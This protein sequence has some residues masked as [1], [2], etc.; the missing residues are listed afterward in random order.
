MTDLELLKKLEWSGREEGQAMCPG[1]GVM[2]SCCP[3]CRGINP[4][5]GHRGGFLQSCW[6]HRG[7]CELGKLLGREDKG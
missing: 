2:V 1:C 3:M 6:G 5:D 7:D 4:L